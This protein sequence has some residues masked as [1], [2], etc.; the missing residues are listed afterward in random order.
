MVPLGL[1]NSQSTS[2]SEVQEREILFIKNT[3]YNLTRMS[4]S[5]RWKIA[6][7]NKMISPKTFRTKWRATRYIKSRPMELLINTAIAI[8]NKK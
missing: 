5:E 2:T 8:C 3:P 7:G 4:K 1:N 6:I